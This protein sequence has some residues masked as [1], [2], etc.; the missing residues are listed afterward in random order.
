MVKFE[1]KVKVKVMDTGIIMG[2]IPRRMARKSGNLS[3]LSI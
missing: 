2:I 3:Y 1:V